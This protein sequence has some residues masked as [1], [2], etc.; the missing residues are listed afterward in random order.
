MPRIWLY[1]SRLYG[2]NI[3][4]VC[5]LRCIRR[6]CGKAAFSSLPPPPPSPFFNR[7]RI[8]LVRFRPCIP[9]WCIH[10]EQ[11]WL[12]NDR[13]ETLSIVYISCVWFAN[14]YPRFCRCAFAG[15][16]CFPLSPRF[17]YSPLSFRVLFAHLFV[18]LT[19]RKVTWHRME[20]EQS[21]VSLRAPQPKEFLCKIV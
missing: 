13:W 21:V 15:Y 18:Y 5:R 17:R 10:T 2:I 1:L 8:S 9:L 12:D 3:T 20:Y 7:E 11:Q 14:Y 19:S 6:V 4:R 16:A